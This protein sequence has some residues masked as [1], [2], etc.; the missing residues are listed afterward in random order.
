MKNTNK[1]QKRLEFTQL[2]LFANSRF[3]AFSN[4]EE[5]IDKQN[6]ACFELYKKAMQL[7]KE[8]NN[9]SNI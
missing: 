2:L 7:R 3:G 8:I 6:K 4:S 5:E 9:E 1:L